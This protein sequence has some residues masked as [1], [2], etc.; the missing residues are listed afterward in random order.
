MG[1]M[2]EHKNSGVQDMP[3][4]AVDGLTGFPDTVAAVFLKTEVQV[5][6]VHM[7]RNSVLFVPYKD[8]KSVSVGL[9]NIARKWTMTIG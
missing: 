5:R 6:I 3:L 1:I 7:V 9:K 4:A 8:R 2:N